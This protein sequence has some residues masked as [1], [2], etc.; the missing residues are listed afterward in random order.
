MQ[1]ELPP[2]PASPLL[3]FEVSLSCRSHLGKHL[4]EGINK[5][6][7][8]LS[9]EA[10]LPPRTPGPAGPVRVPRGGPAAQSR[11]RGPGL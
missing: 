8:G 4:A 6:E 3:T 11:E 10:L 7:D 9:H 1:E 5:S 2:L